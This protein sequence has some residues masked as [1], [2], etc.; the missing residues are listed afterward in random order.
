M[1]LAISFPV[2]STTVLE[3]AKTATI[4]LALKSRRSG[5][6]FALIDIRNKSIIKSSIWAKFRGGTTVFEIAKQATTMLPHKSLGF[7]HD[8]W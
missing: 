4:S 2:A 6:T 5:A 7:R 8:V 3:T 1:V